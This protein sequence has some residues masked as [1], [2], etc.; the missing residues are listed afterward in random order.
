MSSINNS[1]TFSCLVSYQSEQ[2]KWAPGVMIGGCAFVVSVLSIFL[3]ETKGRELPQTVDDVKAWF[4]KRPS[5]IGDSSSSTDTDEE[6]K[7]SMV[8]C[9]DG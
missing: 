8:K 2:A 4:E 5:R 3:P 1:V 9:N 7:M 6:E